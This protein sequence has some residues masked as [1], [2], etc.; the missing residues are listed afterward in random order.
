MRARTRRHGHPAVAAT[1]SLL[2]L[3]VL[4]GACSDN[5]NAPAAQPTTTYQS[6]TTS[7]PGT[8][9]QTTTTTGPTTTYETTSS[10]STTTTETTGPTTTTAA[11]QPTT[12]RAPR[13]PTSTLPR[14]GADAQPVWL[15]VLAFGLFAAGGL[16]L[17]FLRPRNQR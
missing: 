1:L 9:Y 15:G 3:A 6:T 10:A 14:T 7:Q 16:L 17:V 13:P 11:Q 2:F 4:L 5:E 8:T 12:T